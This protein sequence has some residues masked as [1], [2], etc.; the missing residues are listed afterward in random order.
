MENAALAVEAG[1]ASGLGRLLDLNQM[2]L[3][4]L[5]LSTGPIEDMCATARAAGALGVGTSSAASGRPGRRLPLTPSQ[6]AKAWLAASIVPS[7]PTWASGVLSR[8]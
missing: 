8:S 5:F 7:A 2:I 3:A 4:G 6:R 1:D